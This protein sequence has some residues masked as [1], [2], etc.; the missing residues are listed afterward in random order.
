LLFKFKIYI[1]FKTGWTRFSDDIYTVFCETVKVLLNI[2]M[3]ISA[4]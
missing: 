2:Q 1:Y 3:N 4:M